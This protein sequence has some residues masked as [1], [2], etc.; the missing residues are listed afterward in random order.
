ML[1][2][3]G[4]NGTNLSSGS[5]YNPSLDSWSVIT[6]TNAPVARS[7]HT[8]VWTGTK[9]IIWGG[10]DGSGAVNTGAMYNPA[11]TF[12]T[13]TSTTGVP[14][15]RYGHAAVWSGSRMIIWGG[16]DGV[17]SYLSTGANFDPDSSTNGIWEPMNNFYAPSGRTDMTFVWT[18]TKLI[19][20][21]GYD[22]ATLDTG[23]IYDPL[24]GPGGDWFSINM[25]GA[26][27]SRMQAGSVW[28][29]N[30]FFVWGGSSTPSP[31]GVATGGMYTPLPPTN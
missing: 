12:W 10:F 15:P 16:N 13:A 17:G 26:P 27:S 25:L 1:V 2:W 9:M 31:T 24:A 8:A 23:G 14:A 4:Y 22:G 19:V 11:T 5:A 6:P 7:K 18:G 30:K 20:W 29:G 28:L 3:G 21:G